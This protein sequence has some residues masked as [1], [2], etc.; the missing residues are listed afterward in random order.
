MAKRVVFDVAL[1]WIMLVCPPMAPTVTPTPRQISE[2]GLR[3][4]T[5]AGWEIIQRKRKATQRKG[6]AL[7]LVP[8]GTL[9][10]RRTVVG[11]QIFAEPRSLDDLISETQFEFQ[12]GVWS[13]RDGGSVEQLKGEGWTGGLA[14]RALPASPQM[15]RC[16]ALISGSGRGVS[17]WFPDVAVSVFRELVRN[18][19]LEALN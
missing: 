2:F 3:F 17:A 13:A 12:E 8:E 19:T 14:C 4:A 9:I 16:E 11:I 10:E 18:L 5:P 1:A 15:P 7:V 6:G